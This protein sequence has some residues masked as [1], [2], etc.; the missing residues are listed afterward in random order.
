MSGRPVWDARIWNNGQMAE[1]CMALGGVILKPK[2]APKVGFSAPPPAP[3]E[4]DP[5]ESA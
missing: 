4:E 2:G 3:P 1:K 5:G